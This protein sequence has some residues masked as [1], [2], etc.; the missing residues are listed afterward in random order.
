MLVQWYKGVVL[1]PESSP[2]NL[3]GS[4]AAYSPSV[5]W[6]QRMLALGLNVWPLMKAGTHEASLWH[7]SCA[8]YSPV[9]KWANGCIQSWAPSGSSSSAWHAVMIRD[10]SHSKSKVPIAEQE[11]VSGSQ[12]RACYVFNK[13]CLYAG[14]PSVTST[15]YAYISMASMRVETSRWWSIDQR[16]QINSIFS[17]SALERP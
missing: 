10:M 13:P 16:R 15:K 9:Q 14:E 2:G 12:T 3:L 8:V 4:S 7:G 1:R 17:H 11:G 6:I 5:L